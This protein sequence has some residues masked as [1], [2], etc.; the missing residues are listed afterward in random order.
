MWCHVDRWIAT[1]ISEKLTAS[2]TTGTLDLLRGG[3]YEMLVMLTEST[4]SHIPEDLNTG[5]RTRILYILRQRFLMW[6]LWTH[7]GS[8]RKAIV[9]YIFLFILSK[10]VAYIR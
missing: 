7:E 8:V 5:V 4:K 9:V 3:S 1:D 2:K 6:V 10:D